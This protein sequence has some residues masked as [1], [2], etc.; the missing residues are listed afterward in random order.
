MLGANVFTERYIYLPSVGMAWLAGLLA[1]RLWRRTEA[2]PAERRALLVASIVLAGLFAARIMTRNRD[3]NNDITLYTQTLALS[4]DADVILDNLALAYRHQGAEEKAETAW[5]RVLTLH[6]ND[7]PALNNLGLLALQRHQYAEAVEFFQRVIAADPTVMNPHLNLGLTYVEMG[8]AAQ[9]ESELRAA[10]A[11]SPLSIQPHNRLGR[12]LVNQGRLDEAE[13]QF[14]AC[15]R[16]APSPETYDFLGMINIRRRA[17][18]EAVR[19]FQ[20]ALSL[21]AADYN[22]HFGLGYIYKA[23]GRMTEALSQYQAG[24]V[25][26]PTD[27]PALAEVQKLR[28]QSAGAPP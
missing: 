14:R 13:E 9:A 8:L 15:I 2:R 7:P 26:N 4:P 1:S 10:V 11:L 17:W 18:E 6:P 16:L 28:Q 21:D 23:T 3:W 22:A 24:L 5:R 19:A 27:A 20:A 25:S 12:L